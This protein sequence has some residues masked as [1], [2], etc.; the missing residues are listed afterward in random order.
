MTGGTTTVEGIVASV[1]DKGLKLQGD[2]DWINYSKFADPP[3]APPCRG[4]HVRL[5]LDGDGYI[6]ALVTGVASSALTHGRERMITR[7][8]AA[9][10]AGELLAAAIQ[11]CGDARIDHFP[12]VAD[13]V[14]AWLESDD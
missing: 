12:R 8:V 14:L 11:N 4:Q 13:L 2:S 9:K 1:N 3:I 7:Q 6:R 10:V 5:T